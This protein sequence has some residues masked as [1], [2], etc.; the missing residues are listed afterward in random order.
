[1]NA[2][3]YQ[4]YLKSDHWQKFRA[5]MFS[6]KPKC[7]F[8]KSKKF[9]HIHHLTYKNVG[10]ETEKDVVIVCRV[11]HFEL[12]RGIISMSDLKYRI[13]KTAN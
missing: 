2:L 10:R 6:K 4:E 11:H 9:L 5:K 13:E 1:M 3:Q 7:R 8:C 12:H